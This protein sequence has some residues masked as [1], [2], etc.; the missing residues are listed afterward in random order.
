MAKAKKKRS[1]FLRIIVIGVSVYIIS[2]LIS[3]WNNLGAKKAELANLN[4]QYSNELNEVNELR[5]LLKNGS[6]KQIVEKAARQRLGFVYSN[7]EIY[8]DI[9]G[10]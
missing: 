2:T 3:L 9:S 6:K 4:E 7:E 10:N 8:V 5:D 1:L